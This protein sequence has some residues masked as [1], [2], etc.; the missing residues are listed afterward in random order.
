MPRAFPVR[1]TRGATHIPDAGA[2]AEAVDTAPSRCTLWFTG[3]SGAGKSTLANV[4]IRRLAGRGRPAYV[5]GGDFLRRGLSSDVGFS[6]DDRTEKVRRVA[7]VCRLMNDAGVIAAAAL[8]SP[9]AGDRAMARRIVGPDSF[10]EVYHDADLSVCERRDPKVL[11]ARARAGEI[12]DFTGVS[13]PSDV[14]IS[15]DALVRTGVHAV[16][17]CV[18]QL[19][20][21]L[22]GMRRLGR[23]GA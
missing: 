1:S 6:P 9:Q 4:L 16:D 2:S 12:P 20:S 18:V 19:L 11:Y 15:P 13:A 21:F 23:D 3:L 10:A 17:A 5:L 22:D 7:K 8:I 14:P